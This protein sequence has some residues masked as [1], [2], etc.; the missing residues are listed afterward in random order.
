MT[1]R[2]IDYLE[3]YITNVCNLTCE[4]CNRFNNH[5]FKG[6]QKWQDYQDI[7]AEWGKYISIDHLVIMGGECLLNPDIIQWATGLKRI[8]P[9]AGIELLSNGYHINRVPGLY[10]LLSSQMAW[11]GITVH[12]TDTQEQLFD[13]IRM[14]LKSPIIETQHSVDVRSFKDSNNIKITTGTNSEFTTSAVIPLTNDKFSLH[15]SDPVQAHGHCPFAQNKCYH[16]SHGKLYKC[17]PVALFPEFDEQ[18][19]LELSA[20]DKELLHSYQPLSM[21]NYH[22]YHGIFFQELHNPIPQCKF[23]PDKYNFQKI[24]PVKK[25]NR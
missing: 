7:Y 16:M 9:D 21:D 12:N 22:Q 15:Q 23:C 25:N 24:Y 8:W 20:A 3:F 19:D 5:S 18:F 4:N 2:K 13:E 6:W 11:L 1:A 17:G 14:F 10:Q